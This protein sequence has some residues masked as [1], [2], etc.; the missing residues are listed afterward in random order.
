MD[1]LRLL[2][3][4]FFFGAYTTGIVLEIYVRKRLLGAQLPSL[5]RV[6]RRWARILLRGTGV[7]LESSGAV[8]SDAG[9]IVANHRSYLDPIL[10]IAEV[11]A[12]PLC[13]AEVQSWPIIGWGAGM[14][15]VLFVHRDDPMHRTSMVRAIIQK[16]QQG[17]PVLIFPEGTTSD[18]P[19]TLPFQMGAF[20]IAAHCKLKVAPVVY[21][22][23]DPEDFWVGDESFL[24]HAWRR[25]RQKSIRVQVVYGPCLE[26][27][28][29]E[30]LAADAQ[31]FMKSVLMP[32]ISSL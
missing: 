32:E 17:F 19:C 1:Y 2:R 10:F 6:R 23:E 18:E 20:Q 11:D 25:F 9:M 21:I 13:M 5:M 31:R 29:P 28:D 14:S 4:L 27:S 30:Q 12:V 24:S 22:F 15:G 26:S 3:R 16:A 7:R 8:P